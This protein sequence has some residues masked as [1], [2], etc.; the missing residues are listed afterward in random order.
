MKK[1]AVLIMIILIIIT[2]VLIGLKVQ[3]PCNSL[4]DYNLMEILTTIVVTYGIYYLSKRNDQIKKKM[5][6]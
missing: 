1:H 5:R 3:Y 2:G 4:F 6:K